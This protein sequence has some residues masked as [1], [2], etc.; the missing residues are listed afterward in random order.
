M[1][2]FL[3]IINSN[4]NKQTKNKQNWDTDLKHKNILFSISWPDPITPTT[5]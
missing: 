1:L 2:L 5:D 3:P 4:P